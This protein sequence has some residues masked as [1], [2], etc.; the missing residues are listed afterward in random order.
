MAET[1][2]IGGK[3][4]PKTMVYAGGALTAG[5]VGYAWW[6]RSRDFGE[7][8][9]D[10]Y[11]EDS[12]GDER[13]P[14]TTIDSSQV[15]V[16]TRA[17]LKTDQEWFNAALEKLL[18]DYGVADT[19]TA[20]DALTRYLAR[21][22]LTSA[23]IKMIQYVINSLGPP[24]VSGRLPL[25]QAPAVP[26]PPPTSP[27]TTTKPRAPAWVKVTRNSHASQT[28]EWE[29]VPNATHY[30]IQRHGP[31]P[32]PRVNVGNTTRHQATTKVSKP[33]YYAWMVWSGN[34]AG[35]SNN[36]TGTNGVII[37]P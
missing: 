31:V 37:R 34:S 28:I 2:T 5:I 32:A 16:D 10:T 15:A 7:V 12:Y 24:P 14:P 27:P 9:E 25:N 22:D 11:L 33:E 1:V 13:I 35:V 8:V 3:Q 21:Q 18:F 23:Q 17:G 6:T 26:K 19:A 29:K 20:S 30:L 4:F 36:W